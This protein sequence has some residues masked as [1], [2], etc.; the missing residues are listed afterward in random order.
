MNMQN[1]NRLFSVLMLVMTALS[2]T[3][4]HKEMNV[5]DP[6]ISNEEVTIF[7]SQVHCSWCVDFT[8][9]FQ[10]GV[11][12]SPNENMTELRRV[13][14]MKEEDK[15]VAVVDGL[16]TG[17]KYYYRIVVWN[18]LNSYE[19]EMKSFAT[20][21]TYTVNLS[22]NP[23]EGGTTLGGGTFIVGDTCTVSISTNVGYNFVNWTENG[24]QVTTDSE[25][26]FTVMDN[27]DL[28]ANFSLQEYEVTLDSEDGGTVSGGGVCEYGQI[29]TVRAVASE[30]Y[31]FVNWTEDGNKV[32]N[33]AEYSFMVTSNRQIM[34]NFVMVPTGAIKGLF[35]IDNDGNQVF[36]S[37][38]NLEYIK[39]TQTWCFMEHQYD[40][41]ETYGDVG[42]DY[43]NYDTV[44][45]FGWATSGC[46]LRGIDTNYYYH[47]YNT[48]TDYYSYGPIGDFDLTG[49]YANGDWGVYNCISNGGNTTNTWR[50][51]T[52]YEWQYVFNLRITP[53][54]L[55]YAKAHVNGVDGVILLPDNW[56]VD[57]FN[58]TGA[59]TNNVS[60][61]SNEISAQQWETI[62]ESAGAVFFPAAGER[63][64]TNVYLGSCQYWSVS[65]HNDWS[66]YLIS[67]PG[68]SNSLYSTGKNN[69]MTVRL[70]RHVQ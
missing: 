9:Q 37:Q 48:N 34:A 17:T 44:S 1:M 25:Y 35:T 68:T 8:G 12:L 7:G 29:C 4:C 49:E 33:E 36:F 46:N 64:G 20:S 43:A 23:E 50:V 15:Y 27:H 59:N 58:L 6:A 65:S 10:T 47:P 53:S 22:C 38:G 70:V 3:S 26:S 31:I 69:G 56:K 11:E 67:V 16:S 61:D 41:V 32:S 18:K 63:S 21:P 5:K 57:I 28:V 13:E 40:V 24:N 51:L 52:T 2:G 60:Y 54:R 62:L 42:L 45:L 14:A 19:Q 39:S 30:G 55:R 66:A